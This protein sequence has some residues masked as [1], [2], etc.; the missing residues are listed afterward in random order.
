M[1]IIRTNHD[2]PTSYLYESTKEIIGEA[3]KRGFRIA[4]LEGDDIS[5]KNLK[6][7]I[8]AIKPKFIFFNGHGSSVSLY[9][10]NKKSFV[11]TASSEVFKD[12]VTFTRACNC[13]KELGPYAIKNGCHA[14]IGYKNKFWIARN[15]KRTCQPLK[16]KV[17]KPILECSNVIAKELI[18]GKTVKDAVQKS[19]ETS[20]NYIMELIFSKEP[21]APA[22]LQAVVANDSS[23]GFEG[24]ASA[25]IC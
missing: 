2:I 20:A 1:I 3:T 7:K 17:A 6:G 14:F 8:K 5:L 9:D 4:K 12:T 19:Y 15:H 23:L 24:D 16:D 13:L 18:K 11:D 10:N 22:S 25:R 21:L